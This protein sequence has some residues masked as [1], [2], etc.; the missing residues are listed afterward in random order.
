MLKAFTGLLLA[1]YTLVCWI[2]NIIQLINCD[3]SSATSWK[4]E[5]FHIV[6]IFVV[7]LDWI[8]VWCNLGC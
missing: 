5:I 4:A 1:V 7:P 6:G 8:I 3:F 2:T